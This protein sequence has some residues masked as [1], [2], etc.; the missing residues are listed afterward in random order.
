MRIVVWDENLHKKEEEVQ[1]VYPRGIAEEIAGGINRELSFADNFEVTCLN[2][3][4]D[5][6]GLTEEILEKTDVLIFWAHRTHGIF[7][8]EIVE[9]IYNRVM[10]GMGLIVLHSAHLSKVFKR[11]MGTSCTLKYRYGDFARIW[12]TSPSH[13]IAKGIPEFFDLEEEEMY[14]EF[15]DIPKPDDVVFTTWFSGG[16]LFRGGC[17]WQRGYGK[18]FYFHPGHDTNSAYY[19]PLVLKVISN[20]VLWAAPIKERE[21]IRCEEYSRINLRKK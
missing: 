6:F 7:S 3:D 5:E 14:G 4:M 8:D 9:R 1:K 12:T 20:A 13:P 11:L 10:K 2:S 17:T 21:D 16:N 18:V 15:F 19:N